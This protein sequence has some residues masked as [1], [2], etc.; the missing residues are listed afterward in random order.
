MGRG[1]GQSE[2]SVRLVSCMSGFVSRYFGRVWVGSHIEG[3]R[4][5]GVSCQMLVVNSSCLWLLP[6]VSLVLL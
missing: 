4:L 1:A 3:T 6:A 5:I 2:G